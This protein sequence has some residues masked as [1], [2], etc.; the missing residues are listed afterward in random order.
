MKKIIFNLFISLSVLSCL[1]FSSCGKDEPTPDTT[2]TSAANFSFAENGNF[3]PSK[4]TFLNS[5]TNADLYN[6]DF[7]DGQSSTDK[8]PTHVF[9]K[10][11]TYNVTL[12]A[13]RIGGTESIINKTVTVKNVPTKLIIN[14]LKLTAFPAT[15]STG[16][17]WDYLDGPDIFFEITGPGGITSYKE[18]RKENLT[19]GNLPVTFSSG[20]PYTFTSFD[21]RHEIDFYDY[22]PI[23]SNESM[24]GYYFTPRQ[25]MPVN[26]DKYPSTLD[27]SNATSQLKFTLNVTWE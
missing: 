15:T 11:G 23:G 24:G 27:F 8:D 6:W 12:K 21:F 17:G 13:R 14:S 10:G 18:Y 1:F 4:F 3:A 9:T 19:V 16:A 2:A 25:F 20:L 5:S 22:D 26:G 7:G